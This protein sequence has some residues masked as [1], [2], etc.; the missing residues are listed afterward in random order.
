MFLQ[1]SLYLD[2]CLLQVNSILNSKSWIESYDM[3]KKRLYQKIFSDYK[4]ETSGLTS[5]KI[6]CLIQKSK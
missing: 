5:L 1:E 2:L 3:I 4:L 6:F